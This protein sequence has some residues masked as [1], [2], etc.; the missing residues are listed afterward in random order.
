MEY[1]HE[2]K[3][4][5]EYTEKVDQIIF[6]IYDSRTPEEIESAEQEDPFLQAMNLSHTIVE[7]EVQK[8]DQVQRGERSP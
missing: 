2:T 3:S 5:K 8:E 6:D 7:D 4:S 1:K